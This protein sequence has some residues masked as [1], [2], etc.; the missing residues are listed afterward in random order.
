M[1]FLPQMHNLHGKM[2][3]LRML[4]LTMFVLLL[5]KTEIVVGFFLIFI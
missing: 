1:H 2:T 4:V 5:M 3:W